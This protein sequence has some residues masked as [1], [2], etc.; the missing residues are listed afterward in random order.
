[1]EAGLKEADAPAGK[2]LALRFTVCALPE[3]IAVL[4]V[5]VPLAPCAIVRLL[6]DA[7]IEKS[8]LTTG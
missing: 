2:P 8:L 7:L 6:G 5:L 4:M 3:V 1:M